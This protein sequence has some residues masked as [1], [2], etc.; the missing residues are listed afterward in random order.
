MLMDHSAIMREAVCMWA[1]LR[2][3][4]YPA[5]EIYFVIGD[6]KPLRT[7]IFVKLIHEGREAPFRMGEVINMTGDQ[8]K[9]QWLAICEDWKKAPEEDR[10]MV[11]E[12]SIVSQ[13]TTGLVA[14]MLRAGFGVT[15]DQIEEY[16]A[17]A[18]KEA[19]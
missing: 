14:M 19:S 10:Q 6:S 8:A 9:E 7:E 2:K 3:M 1:L 4:S 13:R 11:Y 12:R 17:K 18:R 15:P 16:D 5:E